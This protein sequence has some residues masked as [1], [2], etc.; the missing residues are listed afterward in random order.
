MVLERAV[1]SEKVISLDFGTTN[2]HR[3]HRSAS[4]EA[5]LDESALGQEY[6]VTDRYHGSRR[7]SS[8]Y[9]EVLALSGT[10][11]TVYLTLEESEAR[12]QAAMPARLALLVALDAA[13]CALLI[14]RDRQHRRSQSTHKKEESP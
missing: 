4:T 12:R 2:P 3:I 8:R 11:G 13:V 10:D 6:R 7:G 5:L 14:W 1:A 9:Y